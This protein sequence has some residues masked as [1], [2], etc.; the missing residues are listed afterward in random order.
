[1]SKVDAADA[2]NFY[3]R[4]GPLHYEALW[5]IKGALTPE[6][7]TRMVPYLW[8]YP[9]IRSLLCEAGE[10]ISAED[11]S[12]R[13]L[14]FN[15]P[16]T[17]YGDVARATDTLW[18]AVQLILPG[19]IAPAHRHTPA[20][21]RLVIEGR[22]GYT[23]V[24]ED[25]YEMHPGDLILTPNWTWHA[26]GHAGDA[27]MLWLDGLDL[28]LIHSLHAVFA[29]FPQTDVALAARQSPPSN[30]PHLF[31]FAEMKAELEARRGIAGDP[32]DDVVLEYRN[33]RTGGPIMPT[34]SAAMQLLRPGVATGAHRHTHSVVYHVVCGHGSSH[35]GDQRFDWAPGDT[36][37]V[38]TW[39]PHRHANPTGDDA[40]LFSFSD[41]PVLSALG[42]ARQVAVD[43]E[44]N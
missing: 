41:Y 43:V 31:P 23:T 26:H 21:L 8:R 25:R 13:V 3:D 9:E 34:I 28:P 37:A 18:A 17:G 7:A 36:F 38:P 19:E 16:G 29:E 20:A 42:L 12:R 24:D 32:F 44:D 5:R 6:P 11:A 14:A 33:P 27:P 39:V 22:G 4:L 1:M 30:G 35:V 40:M 2:T 10:V 15:N